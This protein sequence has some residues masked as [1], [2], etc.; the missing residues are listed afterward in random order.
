MVVND[1]HYHDWK[2]TDFERFA[3]TIIFNAEPAIKVDKTEKHLHPT[4]VFQAGWKD[5]IFRLSE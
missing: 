5:K 4:G 1:G 3:E 2:V